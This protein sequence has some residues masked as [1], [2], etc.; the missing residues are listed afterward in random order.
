[1]FVREVQHQVSV[2]HDAQAQLWA[3]RSQLV[4]EQQAVAED[5]ARAVQHAQEAASAHTS[6]LVQRKQGRAQSVLVCSE[7]CCNMSLCACHI[8]CGQRLHSGNQV[9]YCSSACRA[10]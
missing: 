1:M 10:A 5:K 3:E 9:L 8:T 6:L 7:P 2:V 4:I